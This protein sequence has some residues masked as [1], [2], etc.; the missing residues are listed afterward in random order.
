MIAALILAV[1]MPT[2]FPVPAEVCLFDF[3]AGGLYGCVGAFEA[4]TIIDWTDPAARPDE[5]SGSG[6]MI[7]AFTD[8]TGIYPVLV[9]SYGQRGMGYAPNNYVRAETGDVIFFGSV[10]EPSVYSISVD[11]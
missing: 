9:T 10:E 2:S 8:P 11:P 4:N 7:V 6:H 3:D 1:A 5:F